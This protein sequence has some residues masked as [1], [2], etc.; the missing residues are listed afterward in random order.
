[1]ARANSCVHA[2]FCLVP[3]VGAGLRQAGG[4]ELLADV[5]EFGGQASEALVLVELGL[6]GGGGGGRQGAGGALA[7][8]VADEQ[9]VGAMAGI[10]FLP[11]TAGGG[12][13]LHVAVDEG[14]GAHVTDGKEFSED[15]AAVLLEG[16]DG[17]TSWHSAAVL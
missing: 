10:A 2:F 1:M 17:G 3:G 4:G 5:D 14:A 13:A 16:R 11:A 12:A 9:D 8:E 6:D 15:A 7:I